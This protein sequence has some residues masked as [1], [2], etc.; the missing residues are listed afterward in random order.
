MSELG[1]VVCVR[2]WKLYA[3]AKRQLQ[4]VDPLHNP[5]PDT[6]LVIREI[7]YFE[8]DKTKVSDDGLNR[9]NLSVCIVR[10]VP[11]SDELLLMMWVAREPLLP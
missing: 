6:P 2:V 7:A 8:R 4:A 5:L 3:H 10:P 11:G 9:D 1:S